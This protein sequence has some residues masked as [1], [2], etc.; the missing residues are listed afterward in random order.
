MSKPKRPI[1][2]EAFDRILA[3]A[4]ELD[5]E[6][7]DALSE[8]DVIEAGKELG[9]SERAVRQALREGAPPVRE[10][11]R[12]FD[13][14]I[15]IEAERDG[16]RVTM[17]PR[18][19]TLGTLGGIALT[20]FWFSFISL[21]TWGAAHG[22]IFFAL[23]SLPFWFVGLGM[24]HAWM[25]GAWQTDELYLR[26]D[27][28]VLTSRLGPLRW[29]RELETRHLRS[30]WKPEVI[31]EGRRAS[32][33]PAHLALEHGTKTLQLLSGRSEAELRWVNEE[34]ALWLADRAAR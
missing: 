24:V 10:H 9:L 29:R 26:P 25:K 21:W 8:R 23:F 15:S 14:A 31:G 27:A 16:L 32:S 7:D 18:G 20:I 33:R 3:R 19:F 22:S 4:V 28:T 30:S 5:A 1:D 34:L 13:T 12:P 17:P 6:H 11:A 2:R